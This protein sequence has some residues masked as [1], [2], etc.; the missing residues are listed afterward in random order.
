MATRVQ[1]APGIVADSGVLGGKPCVEG[2][3]IPVYLVVGQL[4]SGASFEEMQREYRLTREQCLAC[5][6]Y[7]AT[8]LENERVLAP[9]S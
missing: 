5:L 9:T 4:S 8:R 2:T 7:A 1:L 3:R 6:A